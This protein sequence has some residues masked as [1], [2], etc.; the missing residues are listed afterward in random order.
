MLIVLT[1]YGCQ[2]V[3]YARKKICWL[4]HPTFPVGGIMGQKLSNFKAV[5]SS[6]AHQERSYK[7]NGEAEENS[8]F[9]PASNNINCEEARNA[10]QIDNS[11]NNHFESIYGTAASLLS[12]SSNSSS[13]DE[14]NGN[15]PEQE[16]QSAPGTPIADNGQHRRT[17]K[18]VSFVN[19]KRS[20][21]KSL[22]TCKELSE[23]RS[24]KKRNHWVLK[25][26]CSRLRTGCSSVSSSSE[27]YLPEPH[28][29][30]DAC[31]CTGYRRTEEHHLG[32]GVVFEANSTDNQTLVQVPTIMQASSQSSLQSE[33]QAVPQTSAETS[34]ED[35]ASSPE[36]S[37]PEVKH[38]LCC[39]RDVITAHED[40]FPVANSVIDLSK[41]NPD[42]YPI[43]DCDERARI[44]RAR[45]IAEGVEPPP[46]FQPGRQIQL[47]CT[48]DLIDN[49]TA[50]FQTHL[51]ISASALT[52]ALAHLEPAVNN[53]P[54]PS[55]GVHTQVDYIHCLV[56]DLLQITSCSYYWGKMDRYEAE[57][58]LD[59]KAEGTFLLRDSAQ[60]EYLF[61]VTF[62]KYGL[63]LHARIEQWNHKFSFDSHDP[64][65]FASSTVCGLIEHYKD[66]TCCMFF[67][68]MLTIPLHRNFP[69]SLQHLSRA[70]VSS[71]STYDGI[72]HLALPKALK[73]YL[74]E[75]HY[76]QRV[77]VRRFDH[78]H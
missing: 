65:V 68:P 64:G 11:L 48:P 31:V 29:S 70:V 53:N 56:P 62:R 21:S 27:T 69:F 13:Q 71:H 30:C 12:T 78:D 51:G 34:L 10:V 49:I 20:R 1:G 3:A 59:G 33:P 15:V 41:F 25:F 38:K 9:L 24:K 23:G 26:N 28:T 61:S 47:L 66:P 16:T 39:G 5:V 22:Q 63:S 36:S 42:D 45:E 44:E 54:P 4:L 18:S 17:S 76:K 58:L 73:S 57:R 55:I 50:L 46:G 43:E 67:E 60:E 32:A 74:K 72:N 7:M 8:N 14:E 75:Y 19:S 77:R 52:P 40:G 2:N 35:S 37:V 6:W